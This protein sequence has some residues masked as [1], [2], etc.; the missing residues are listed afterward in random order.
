MNRGVPHDASHPILF[1]CI[2]GIGRPE[3]E[4]DGVDLDR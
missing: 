1:S 3:E 4:A 2:I